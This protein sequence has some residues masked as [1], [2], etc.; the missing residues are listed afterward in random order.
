[1]PARSETHTVRLYAV[2]PDGPAPLAPPAGA[3]SVH[4]VFD[5]LPLGVYSGLR[6]YDGVRFLRLADHVE[7]TQRSADALG[8][9][10]QLDRD[11][12]ARALDAAVR[13][14]PGDARV[15]FDVLSGPAE[16]LGTDA[17]VLVALSPFDPVPE[18]LRR[19]GVR[20]EIA[21]GLSRDDPEVK[22]ASFVLERRPFPIGTPDRYEQLLVGADG[23][24]LEGSSSNVFFVRDGYLHTA[25]EGVLEG[26]TR[27]IV[28]ELAEACGVPVR[29]TGQREHDLPLVHEAFLS[30]SSR[31]VV[32][33]REVEGVRIGSGRPGPVTRRL[34][35]AYH[36]YARAEARPATA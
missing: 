20:C 2:L 34:A 17:R 30:S 32:P 31:D 29:L 3:A 28:L 11:A 13:E 33:I 19:S 26:V 10:V 14:W 5:A 27:R 9:G 25:D 18:E 16:S 15:R 36:R 12:L 8:L 24:L 35:S 4:E 1:M 23:T 7:R 22:Q 6:T 21:R